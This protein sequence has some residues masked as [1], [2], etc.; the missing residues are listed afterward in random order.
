MAIEV[1]RNGEAIKPAAPTRER[2]TP[3]RAMRELLNWD[4]FRE[5]APALPELTAEFAPSFDIKETADGYVFT[6]DVPGVK[7]SDLD[8][9]VS[10]NRLRISGK[11]EEEK[12]EKSAQYY[13]YERSFGSFARSFTLPEGADTSKVNAEL[14][15]GVLTLSIGKTR[16]AQ[17]Q[18]I[19]INAKK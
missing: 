18:K 10:G 16:Q 7:E 5:M 8:I 11:R 12:E 14:K 9:N 3:F 19:A 17:A 13:A 2:L 4:P 15:D 1:R 6:A